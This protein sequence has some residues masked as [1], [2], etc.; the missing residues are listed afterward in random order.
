MSQVIYK[1]SL[2]K[3][4]ETAFSKRNF[5]KYFLLLLPVLLFTY[6]TFLLN[7]LLDIP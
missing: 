4:K 2:K 3:I 6:T 1:I 7:G 5:S